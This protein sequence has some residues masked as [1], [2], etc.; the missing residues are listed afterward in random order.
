MEEYL[1][2]LGRLASQ[3]TG[4]TTRTAIFVLAISGVVA[5]A[6][7]EAKSG[8][9][10]GLIGESDFGRLEKVPPSQQKYKRDK[11][12]YEEWS[13][14]VEFK[15]MPTVFDSTI[16]KEGQ[17]R[18]AFKSYELFPSSSTPIDEWIYKKEREYENIENQQM[19][20]QYISG[21]YEYTTT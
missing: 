17:T 9:W 8:Q 1:E 16:T 21:V 6:Y 19:K 10:T 7:K 13:A 18:T 15:N 11:G 12:E 4:M 2:N 14:D 5:Y 3:Q 20:D